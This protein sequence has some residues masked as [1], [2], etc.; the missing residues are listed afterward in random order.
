MMKKLIIVTTALA[1]VVAMPALAKTYRTHT[2]RTHDVTARTMDNFYMRPRPYIGFGAAGFGVPYGFYGSE[3]YAAAPYGFYGGDA[4]AAAPY[5]AYGGEAYAAVTGS[6]GTIGPVVIDNGRYLGA[7]PD[8]NVRLQLL[9][10]SALR[11]AP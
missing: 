8:P 5:G 10:D 9:R 11:D 4:Y 1:T 7:D 6:T 2:Y 3:A